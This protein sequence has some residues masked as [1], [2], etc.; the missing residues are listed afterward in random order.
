V[1]AV[2]SELA[3]NG[4]FVSDRVR[5]A[6]K[7]IKEWDGLNEFGYDAFGF[8]PPSAL[9]AA[10][11][12]DW[13][14][15][16]YFRVEAD[17]VEHV[18]DTGR[19]FMFANHSGQLPIDGA[20]IAAAQLFERK[21]PRMVRSMF[22]N[23]FPRLP[24]VGN[25]L[26]RVGQVTGMPE[27]CIRLL[28]RDQC[29]LTFP[30]GTRGSGKVWRDRYTLQP[31]GSGFVRIGL[32]TGTPFVPVAV[33]GGEEQIPSF[34]NSKILAKVLSMPYFPLTPF[35]PW[36]G[37]LGGLPMPVKY[38]IRFGKPIHLAGRGDESDEFI[39]NHIETLRGAL[40]TLLDG[41]L[42]ERE[43]VFW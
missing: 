19:V 27:N 40:K 25:F 37:L 26:K 24:Y 7:L 3:E 41:L 13:L 22:D 23:W 15:S 20:L 35:F 18:P 36:F 34:H 2:L 5:W 6:A 38:R 11:A 39:A 33:V 30:E 31:F 29:L 16:K 1:E 12:V 32:E 8:H 17:G 10:T 28:N 43:N 21:H 14:Y 9:H 4:L 42:E